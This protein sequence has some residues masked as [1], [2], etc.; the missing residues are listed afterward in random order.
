M[1][2]NLKTS[3]RYLIVNILPLLL[4]NLS[5]LWNNSLKSDF[6]FPLI[7][8]SAQIPT[9]ILYN[10]FL[11]KNLKLSFC[12]RGM[13]INF[14]LL[15]IILHNREHRIIATSINH[16]GIDKTVKGIERRSLFKNNV[17]VTYF[18]I[19]F[20]R[21]IICTKGSRI[22]GCQPHNRD[23]STLIAITFPYG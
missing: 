21:L 2:I 11:S 8:N 1:N 10:S 23:G 19:S 3:A 14:L 16:T 17:F 15:P 13:A 6:N 22:Q 12:T 18:L 7:S 9:T 20:L 5:I 4:H